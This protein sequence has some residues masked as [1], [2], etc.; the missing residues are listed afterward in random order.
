MLGPYVWDA[1]GLYIYNVIGRLGYVK[2]FMV[3][4]GMLFGFYLNCDDACWGVR[5]R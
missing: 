5:M 2:G 3:D 4:V 1:H